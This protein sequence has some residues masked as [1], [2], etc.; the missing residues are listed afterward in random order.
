MKLPISLIFL[1]I[2]IIG[3]IGL[4]YMH[5]Q[6]HV[7]IYKSYGIESHIDLFSHFPH[8]ATISE[9]SCDVGTCELAHN[10]N[11][12]ISYPILIFY[13]VFGLAMFIIILLIESLV[14]IKINKLKEG[15][16]ING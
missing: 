2:L 12:S 3:Y 8:F 13:F 7:E 9:E 10:I 6:V 14:D 5:E 15:G 1:L 4:G 11:E 16:K